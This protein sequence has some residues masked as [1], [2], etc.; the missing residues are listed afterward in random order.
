MHNALLGGVALALCAVVLLTRLRIGFA[1]SVVSIL[2]VPGSL[3]LHNPLTPYAL[4]TRVILVA[5]AIRLIREL[6]RGTV[7]IGVLRWTTVHTAFVVFLVCTFVAG[8]VLADTRFQSLSITESYLLVLDPFL[9]FVV[10]LACVRAIGDLRWCLGVVTAALLGTAGIGIIEHATGG[11]WG[12]FLFGQINP[13]AVASSP[14]TSRFG[15]LRVH[16]GAEYPVQYAWV[17]AMLLPAMLAWLGVKRWRVEVWL[18]ITLAATIVVVL[19]EYW[20]YSRTGFA[21]IGVTAVLASIAARD[22]RMLALTGA[23]L[24]LGVLLF[25]SIG[26]LQHG[27]LGLPS[28]PVQVRTERVP[29]ILGIAAQHPLHGI[30]LGGLAAIGLPNTDSTY[31]QLYGEAGLLGLVSGV[32]LLVCSLAACARGLR[33]TERVDRFAAAAAVAASIAMIVGGVAYDAIRSL[34]SSRPFFLIVAI[35]VLAA[36]RAGGPLP[37]LVRR[38]RL[39]VVGGLVASGAV[40]VVLLAT[41]P[42]HYA[43]QYAFETVSS[44]RQLLPVDP[45]TVGTTYINSVCDVVSAVGTQHRSSHLDCRDPQLAAGVGQI[46]V[47]ADSPVDVQNLVTDVRS[48]VAGLPVDFA[49]FVQ[50]PLRSGRDTG[51]AWAPFW[52]PASV[53]LAML[54][55]PLGVTRRATAR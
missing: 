7:S 35:G 20:S 40:G 41:A 30:G 29:V 27:Y 25:I 4:F 44:A 3:V 39:A 28:G 52:L 18:P 26:G 51:L 14:L 48:T 49:L 1:V 54:L 53:L 16:G 32:A 11:A 9:F 31:L 47:Q 45:V 17:L 43:E 42:T 12:H 13:G 38:P 2:L 6:K 19:A 21:A 10:A 46:R 24:A 33:S 15:H 37:A 55:L 50:T 5:L 8:V 23:G 34:S 36:E 22:K